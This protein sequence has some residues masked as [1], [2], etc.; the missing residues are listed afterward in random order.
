MRLD[1]VDIETII[2]VA[3]QQAPQQVAGVGAEARQD[4]DVML[5]DTAQDLVSAL[6]ALHGLLFEGVDA[7]DH[8]VGEHAKTPP[9]DSKAMT[10]RLDHFWSK[11][12]WCAAEGV[13]LP[14]FEW[15][16]DFA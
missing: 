9:I 6:V 16:F 3:L 2:W 14:A 4:I 11:I 1:L 12:L 5:G 15:L 10:L 7:T 13:R 8:L